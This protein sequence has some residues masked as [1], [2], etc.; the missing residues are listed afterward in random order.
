MRK[1][2]EYPKLNHITSIHSEGL[3]LYKKGSESHSPRTSS[4][5]GTLRL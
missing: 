1:S 2:V 5:E 4:G 3:M